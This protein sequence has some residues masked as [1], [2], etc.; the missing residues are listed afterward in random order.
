MADVEK[1]IRLLKEKLDELE[2]VLHLDEKRAQIVLHESSMQESNF[3]QDANRARRVSQEVAALKAPVTAWEEARQTLRDASEVAT[4]AQEEEDPAVLLDVEKTLADVKARIRTL[5]VEVFFSGEHDSNNAIISLH[6]GAG[7]TDAQDWTEILTR[8][9]IRYAEKKDWTVEIMNESR[10]EE[11][12]YKSVE[13]SVTGFRAYGYLKGEA[14]V[15][16]VVRISPFDAEKMRHTAF[17]LVEVIPEIPEGSVDDIVIDDKDLR[18]DT[19]LS[20]GKGGQSVNT[21]YSAIRITHLPTNTV[22]TC[23]NQRSQQQNKETAMRVLMS[24]L[25]ARLQEEKKEKLDELKGGHTPAAWGNQIR[26]YVLHPYKQ[27]KDHRSGYVTQDV[28]AVLNG[29]LDDLVE[30]QLREAAQEK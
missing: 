14:G 29:D 5:E 3:W 9:F 12:G 7:G 15:H 22:V 11:A 21:T 4:L 16:R 18:I 19:F 25:W 17:A 28:D 24:R 26:S 8:M 20:S 27:V 2:T 30:A 1:D 10:G 13:L 6:A 23:Q